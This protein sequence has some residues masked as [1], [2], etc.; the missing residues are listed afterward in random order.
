MYI[1]HGAFKAP[2][3]FAFEDLHI[4][5][6]GSCIA[7]ERNEGRKKG[8]TEGSKEEKNDRKEGRKKE[9]SKKASKIDR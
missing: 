3:S 9:G 5:L 6:S 1:V 2:M 8:R 4:H 7:C